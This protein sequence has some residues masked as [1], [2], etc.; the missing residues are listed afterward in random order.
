ML[1]I[2]AVCILIVQLFCTCGREELEAY[3]SNFTGTWRNKIP[4]YSSPG[5]P[6]TNY[7][8]IDGEN[9]ELRMRCDV[10]NHCYE[11]VEGKVLINRH[12]NQIM[13]SN[14][15]SGQKMR[16]QINEFPMQQPNGRWECTI[17]N[18]VMIRD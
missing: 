6:V 17:E 11:K 14:P 2:A 3:D 4:Q 10:N 13:F 1:R 15:S 8:R 7:M 9:S 12:R 5:N 18:V 16:F